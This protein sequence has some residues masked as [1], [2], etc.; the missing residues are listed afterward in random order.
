M[1]LCLSEIVLLED[2]SFYRPC[3]KRLQNLPLYVCARYQKHLKSWNIY[4]PVCVTHSCNW[5]EEAIIAIFCLRVGTSLYYLLDYT[6][7]KYSQHE[8][9]SHKSQR[10]YAIGTFPGVQQ[11]FSW[12]AIRA[13]GFRTMVYSHIM[14]VLHL[15]IFSIFI[16][17]KFLMVWEITESVHMLQYHLQ[18]PAY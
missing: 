16:H 7:N 4:K 8:R 11:S 5:V 18:F 10:L 3:Q 9:T 6:Q 17:F 15:E 13:I 12:Y 2:H 1:N 14:T